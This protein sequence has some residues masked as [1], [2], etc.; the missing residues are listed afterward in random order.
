MPVGMPTRAVALL[1]ELTSC[2]TFARKLAETAFLCR[3][4][5]RMVTTSGFEL[6]VYALP[7]GETEFLV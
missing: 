1:F 7:G 3:Q 2:L 4:S 6:P 5:G